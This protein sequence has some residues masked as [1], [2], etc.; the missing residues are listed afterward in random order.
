[1]HSDASC[2]SIIR[3]NPS[4]YAT[5]LAH[6]VGCLSSKDNDEEN[7]LS[8]LQSISYGKSYYLINADIVNTYRVQTHL[9]KCIESNGTDK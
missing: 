1:M 8:C 5:K 4:W 9:Y 7:I 2:V 3:E 6:E